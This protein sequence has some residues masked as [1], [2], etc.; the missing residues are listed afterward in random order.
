MIAV[1]GDAGVDSSYRVVELRRGATQIASESVMRPAGGSANAAAHAAVA[2][3]DV[4]L[5]A[6]VGR[7]EAGRFLHAAYSAIPQLQARLQE[8]DAPTQRSVV[9]VEADGE[10]TI[11]IDRSCKALVPS[12]ED[13]ALIR[14][15]A[16]VSVNL[17]EPLE[18]RKWSVN[19]PGLRVL[20]TAHLAQEASDGCRWDLVVGSLSD[21]PLPDEELL[22][23][24]D[25]QI[26]LMTK[27]ASGGAAWTRADG[28]RRWSSPAV[29]VVDSVGAGDAFLGGVLAAAERSR[30][31]EVLIRAGVERATACLG[32]DG[33]WP[34]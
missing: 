13:A 18:R 12:E 19:C 31:A 1:V 3:A 25:A 24:V 8:Q 30:D 2:G 17:D 34:A 22:A 28:W 26:C 4:T 29:N 23:S 5:F 14:L 15:A 27:G 33:A 10:R 16:V 20:P 6:N 21:H 9:I 11:I 7:D 32:V